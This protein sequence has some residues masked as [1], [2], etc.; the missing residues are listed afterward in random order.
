MDAEQSLSA[1]DQVPRLWKPLEREN[2]LLPNTRSSLPNFSANQEPQIVPQRKKALAKTTKDLRPQHSPQYALFRTFPRSHSPRNIA[3]MA[4][5]DGY[6]GDNEAWLNIFPVRAQ[7]SSAIFSKDAKHFSEK[8]GASPN[9][10]LMNISKSNV[11]TTL[12]ATFSVSN[13]SSSVNSS[14]QI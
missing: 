6:T 12:L 5:F 8:L 1:L 4:H 13:K 14:T 11:S 2:P 10:E 7:C 9:L 3:K